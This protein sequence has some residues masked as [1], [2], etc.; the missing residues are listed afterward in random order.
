MCV[1]FDDGTED[2]APV[3]PFDVASGPVR[4]DDPRALVLAVC[5]PDAAE[6]E[7]LAG[8]PL[9]ALAVAAEHV[10]L[11][12]VQGVEEALR[13]SEPR[14]AYRAR[15]LREPYRTLYLARMT[16]PVMRE[17]EGQRPH[18]LR[19]LSVGLSAAGPE[20]WS[21]AARWP[22][23][24]LLAYIE[25]RAAAAVLDEIDTAVEELKAGA[26]RG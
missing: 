19:A 14:R 2:G 11:A 10:W 3:T 7:R 24:D 22:L 12:L 16:P 4:I 9:D 18:P 1:S 21:A 17:A 25:D 13:T 8:L 15:L 5:D 20:V 6:T 26:R 23:A